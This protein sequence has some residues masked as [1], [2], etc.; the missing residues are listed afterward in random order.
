MDSPEDQSEGAKNLRARDE[1]H[2]TIKEED[3]QKARSIE[4]VE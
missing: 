4:A 3:S 1:F 2:S